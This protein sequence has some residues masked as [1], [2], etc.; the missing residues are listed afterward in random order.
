MK[1][2]LERVQRR[3]APPPVTDAELQQARQRAEEG[4]EQA[5]AVDEQVRDVAARL[6]SQRAENHFGPL[7]WAAL[8][9]E[10]DV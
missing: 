6:R 3:F 9:G 10:S 4:A 7:I 8:R 2:W 1:S 5:D